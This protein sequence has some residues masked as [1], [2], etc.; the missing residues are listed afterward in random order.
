MRPLCFHLC[1]RLYRLWPLRPA[2][3]SPQ[4][5]LRTCVGGGGEGGGG[6]VLRGDQFTIRNL[7][8][9]SPLAARRA[10]YKDTLRGA[11]TACIGVLARIEKSEA[12][13]QH[14]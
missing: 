9:R 14:R 2:L 4:P 3:P 11:R 13:V 5:H 1:L 12:A 8:M 10:E 7:S 6:R